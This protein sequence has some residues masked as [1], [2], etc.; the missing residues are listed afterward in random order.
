MGAD[1]EYGKYAMLGARMGCYSTTVDSND[2]IQI[3][4]LDQMEDI[5]ANAIVDN[6]ME[7]DLKVYGESIRQKLD[8]VVADFNELDS[9]FFKFCMPAH[10]NRGVQDREVK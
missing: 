4:D 7:E 10:I 8:I 9:K 5:F 3:R 2:F 1:V 6:M